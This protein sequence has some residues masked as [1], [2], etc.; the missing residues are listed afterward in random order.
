[1]HWKPA[2]TGAGA[3]VA[4][5][6]ATAMKKKVVTSSPIRKI[7][8]AITASGV[9]THV[10][11]AKVTESAHTESVP[12]WSTGNLT[13]AGST[14]AGDAMEGTKTT[15]MLPPTL[16]NMFAVNDVEAAPLVTTCCLW[17][18]PPPP[19]TTYWLWKRQPPPV[20]T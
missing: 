6:E 20:T 18:R 2:S 5:R 13:D 17:K 11:A 4:V 7:R 16:R 14:V 12:V 3:S 10:V 9:V 1:M 15:Q 19:V 8:T